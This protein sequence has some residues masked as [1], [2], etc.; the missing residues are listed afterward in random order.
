VRTPHCLHRRTIAVF[1]IHQLI[2]TSG[3]QKH[4]RKRYNLGSSTKL[5]HSSATVSA[6]AT[7]FIHDPPRQ[8]HHLSSVTLAC[9][10]V[11]RRIRSVLVICVFV[12]KRKHTQ[13]FTERRNHTSLCK[14]AIA[15]HSR[16]VYLR[17]TKRKHANAP[18]ASATRIARDARKRNGPNVASAARLQRINEYS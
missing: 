2:C 14:I 1:S 11:T 3:H 13:F 4:Q 6:A 10:S 8:H 18:A 16:F 17:P 7:T 12:T 9:E 5:R 15:N